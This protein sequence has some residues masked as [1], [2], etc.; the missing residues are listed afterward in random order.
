MR[1]ITV[2]LPRPLAERVSRAVVRRRSTR[3]ALVREAIEAYLAAQTEGSEGS[4][5]DLAPDLAGAVN[6]PPDLS[7]NRL[8]LKGYGR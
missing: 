4:C 6:G 8:R 3:S 2:K 7:S 5:F 1:T